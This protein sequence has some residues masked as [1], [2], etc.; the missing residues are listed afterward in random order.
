MPAL[1]TAREDDL[2]HIFEHL[3]SV[4]ASLTTLGYAFSPAAEEELSSA[5][6]SLRDPGAFLALGQGDPNPVNDLLQGERVRL[7]DFEYS[8]FRHALMDGVFNRHL[9]PWTRYRLPESML[10]Q[11]EVR[12]RG[13]LARACPEAQDEPHFRLEQ[14]RTRLVWLL[15]TLRFLLEQTLTP[16]L[17][18]RTLILL[19]RF[20]DDTEMHGCLP[21]MSA[22]T[23]E[24]G[25]LLEARWQLT[26]PLL[27]LYPAF[28]L[29][30]SPEDAD[31]G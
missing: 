31:L 4:R 25:A 18:Q 8:G 1:T 26:A 3:V 24:L 6:Q 2:A 28:Q 12:Y 20:T 15:V 11:M 21:A 14:L 9:Y 19:E 27:P 23:K 16:S 22:A 17:C 30:R 7:Y 10:A 13:E 29:L 5:L